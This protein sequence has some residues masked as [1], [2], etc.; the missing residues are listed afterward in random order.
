MS[1]VAGEGVFSRSPGGPVVLV[2]QVGA[3]T[4]S[5]VAAAALACAGSEPDSAALLV[6]LEDGRA[7]R[8]TFVAT[9]GARALEERLVAHLPN[10]AVA[11]R[12][13]ICL[14]K[15]PPGPEGVAAIAT[16]LPLVRESAAVIH[17]APNLLRSVLEEPRIGPTSA[18]LRADLKKDRALTALAARS[19]MAS[20]LQVAVLKRPPG[21]LAARAALLGALF[22]ASGQAL[23]D[24]LRRR[25]LATG[26]QRARCRRP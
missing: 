14:L 19:L 24:R 5:Q 12:G 6:D 20:G 15:L 8:S 18:L 9:A 2:A 11:S 23:P 21:W 13:Q 25:L 7:P 3:A 26:S 10:A 17:L 1:G 16:A 22:S 4:G